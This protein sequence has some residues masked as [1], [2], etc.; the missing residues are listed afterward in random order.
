MVVRFY[1][2]LHFGPVAQLD[3]VTD[4]MQT[5][6]QKKG[7]FLWKIEKIVSKGDYNY[8]KIKGHPNATKHGY[9]L[10]HRIVMENHLDRL[11]NSNEVVHHINRNKKDNRIENLEVHGKSEHARSHSIQQGKKMA[12]LICPA[13]GEKFTKEHRQTHLVKP[14]EWSACSPK[15]RGKFSSKIQYQGK[16]QEVE[17]AISVNILSIYRRYLEDNTEVTHLHEEP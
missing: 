7:A 3:R 1:P 10:H 6:N 12:D 17:D 15:C 8:A 13:C 16:T 11:L 9:V 14:A 2:S 4:F 5:F